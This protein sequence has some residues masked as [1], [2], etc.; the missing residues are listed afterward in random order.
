MTSKE[1]SHFR[2]ILETHR[3]EL[4]NSLASREVIAIASASDLF[5]QIQS[6]SER[7]FAVGYMERE[8]TRLH[9]VKAALERIK[10][11]SFGLCLDCDEAIGPKRLAALPWATAC[12]ACRE[13][14]D[15]EQSLTAGEEVVE[16]RVLAID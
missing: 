3:T 9:E 12:I 11:G 7:D 10:A 13:R 8:S 15:R 1:L 5:D 14:A 16:T 2:A 4:R 6:A